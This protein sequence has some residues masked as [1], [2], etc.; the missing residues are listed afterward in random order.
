[1]VLTEYD[2][3]GYIAYKKKLIREEGWNEGLSEGEL[4][5]LV[6]LICKKLSKGKAPVQIAE[7]LEEDLKTVT[8]ICDA[9]GHFAPDHDCVRIID[10]IRAQK[11][12]D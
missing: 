6:Q 2:E 5:K 12:G 8:Q 7:D 4:R 3:K 11:T 10:R 1:M 9:A